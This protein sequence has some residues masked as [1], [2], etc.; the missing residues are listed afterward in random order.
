[1]Q[2]QAF[3]VQYGRLCDAIA[4]TAAPVPAVRGVE[5]SSNGRGQSP[6]ARVESFVVSVCPDLIQRCHGFFSVAA[7]AARASFPISNNR[8]RAA[9]WCFPRSHNTPSCLSDLIVP[10]ERLVLRA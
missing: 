7:R 1:M 6:L 4:L 9:N 8:L 2:C 3:L 10:H 5:L